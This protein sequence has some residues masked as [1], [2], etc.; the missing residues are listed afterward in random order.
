M[1]LAALVA[2]GEDDAVDHLAQRIGGFDRVR[3]GFAPERICDA[4]HVGGWQCSRLQAMME[5]CMAVIAA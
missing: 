3:L 2:G 4:T 1:E 5:N